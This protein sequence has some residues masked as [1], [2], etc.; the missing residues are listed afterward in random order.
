M[1]PANVI[2]VYPIFTET[3]KHMVSRK[4]GECW[5]EPE[6]EPIEDEGVTVGWLVVHRVMH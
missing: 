2:H 3:S 5:C 6:V 4:E 1:K